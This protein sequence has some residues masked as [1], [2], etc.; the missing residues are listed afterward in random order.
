[1][2]FF[3]NS[4][5]EL[6][7]IMLKDK[8]NN[9]ELTVFT[10]ALPISNDDITQLQQ[11]TPNDYNLKWSGFACRLPEKNFNFNANNPNAFLAYETPDTILSHA[12]TSHALRTLATLF[13]NKLLAQLN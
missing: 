7:V 13:K 2:Q 5:F 10:E 1:M 12:R 9:I 8:K 6:A 4:W 11:F 3:L